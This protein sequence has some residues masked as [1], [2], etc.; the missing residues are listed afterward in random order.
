MCK[1]KRFSKRACSDQEET[2]LILPIKIDNKIKSLLTDAISLDYY[3]KPVYI[4]ETKMIYDQ[5]AISKWLLNSS[6]D[7][8]TGVDIKNDYINVN[9]NIKI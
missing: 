7:P 2:I 4:Q 9:Y 1:N 8:L 5:S 3:I 6:I